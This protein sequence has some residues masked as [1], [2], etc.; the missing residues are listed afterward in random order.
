MTQRICLREMILLSFVTMLLLF[1]NCFQL[2][3]QTSDVNAQG[4]QTGVTKNN[5]QF[6]STTTMR[7]ILARLG[8]L[9]QTISPSSGGDLR[10]VNEQ[11]QPQNEGHIARSAASL[12]EASP[13]LD[14]P[15]DV[16]CRTMKFKIAGE[17]MIDACQAGLAANR[18]LFMANLFPRGFDERNLQFFHLEIFYQSYLGRSPDP[19][20]VSELKVL[21]ANV[22][23]A[24]APAAVCGAALSSMESLIR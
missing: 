3:S 4:S 5:C 16:S 12:G 23:S 6:I 2:S 18:S 11:L 9:D 24:I 22:S 14:L 19:F 13:D 17:L 21:A 20:E 1:Q 8:A 7:S 15:E 10:L